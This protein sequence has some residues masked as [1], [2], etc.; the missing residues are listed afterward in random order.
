MPKYK[1]KPSP[2]RRRWDLPSGTFTKKRLSELSSA[3]QFVVSFL[4][5]ILIGTIGFKVIPGLYVGPSLGWIDALFTATSAICV[6]GLAVVDT[7]A[8]FTK[9]G[10]AYILLLIQLGGVGILTFASL[11]ITAL[12][13]RPSIRAQQAVAGNQVTVIDVPIS[14]IIGDILKFTIVCE[15]IG[16]LVLYLLWAPTRGWQEA[17][18]P[19]IFHSV[20]A[21]CN[22]GFSTN[23]KSLEPFV[24]S[25]ATLVTISLL[26]ILGGIGFIVMEELAA[27]FKKGRLRLNRMSTH[28]KIVLWG[29]LFLLLAPIGFFAMFEWNRTLNGL[30]LG[31][32]LVNAFFMCV[33]PRTAGFNAIDYGQA[34][35]STNFLT[36]M[37]MTIGGAPGSTAGGM[38]VTTFM[39]LIL[40][41]WSRYRGKRGIVAFDRSIPE[42]TA[43]QAIGLFV[44]MFTLSIIG[45]L[46]L[47][48]LDDP[49][50]KDH[51]IFQRAFEVVSAINTVGLSMGITASISAPGKFALVVLMFIG[52]VGPLALS[53]AVESRISHREDFRLAQEDVIIG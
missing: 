2:L 38:K 51:L 26:I 44:V 31:D 9:W 34:A 17:I 14:K 20:S 29:T 15:A 8:F 21:F 42:V 4:A 30:S 10:Q 16:A 49:L 27:Y 25:S 7:A 18:W 39:L 35:D 33:T 12:G 5:L 47:Q 3:E 22:A 11:I 13:G 32:K 23:S 40:M 43:H 28:T 19:S 41:T 48:M 52:R 46:C 45:V 53:A 24:A 1:P 50:S 36:M 6:T 37:L